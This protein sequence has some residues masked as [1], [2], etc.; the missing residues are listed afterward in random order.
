VV[1]ERGTEVALF[2]PA[3]RERGFEVVDVV[4]SEEPLPATLDGFDAVL[5][6]G[7]IVDTHQ[8]DELPWLAGEIELARTALRD[9]VPAVGL[10]LG[11]QI[12][13]EAGGGEV[14]RSQPAEIGWHEV[15]ARPEARDDPLFSALPERFLAFQWHHYACIPGAG[16]VA[17]AANAVAAQALRFSPLAWGTQF[18][19]EVTRAI[20]IGWWEHGGEGPLTE[21]GY[22]RESFEQS[23]DRHLGAH[24]RLGRELG[25]RFAAVAAERAA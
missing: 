22:S 24:E 17:L 10:C 8:K 23:L 1:N 5:L 21:L 15:A 13:T 25:E 11:A 6:G 9:G 16:A 19:V 2:L 4:P 20:L 7:G 12:L 18:H 14:R 3:L